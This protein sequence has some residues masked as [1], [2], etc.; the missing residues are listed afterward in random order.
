MNTKKKGLYV[1]GGIILLIIISAVALPFLVDVNHFRPTI[2]A[3]LKQTLCRP[4]QIGE[5][6]LS[7]LAGG[8]SVQNVVIGEDPAFGSAPFLTAK[9]LDVGVTMLPLLLSRSLDVNSFT[10][11]EPE[12]RLV[13]GNGG[14]WNFSSLGTSAPAPSNPG[15]NRRQS[16]NAPP[17]TQPASS[18]AP[19][20]S[21]GSLRITD[22]KILVSSVNNSRA[23]EYSNVQLKASDI[24]YTSIMP[25]NFEASTP[26]GGSLKADGKAGP[27]DREDTASTPLNA[28]VSIKHLDIASTGFV[29]P[30]SGLA[31]LLDYDGSL[32][33]NGKVAETQGKASVDKL[34]LVRSGSPAR[35]PV[36]FDY[37]TQYDL[38]RQQGSI[39]HGAIQVGKAAAALAGNYGQQGEA[40][41]VHMKFTGNNMPV[42]E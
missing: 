18:A 31:G 22:G 23:H 24:N 16:Q 13:R 1:V 36:R 8:V 2:E 25:F 41:V 6:H 9:S 5:M 15:R 19:N 28:I 4:V 37:S 20:V 27:L 30:A 21:I 39:Q 17:R 32:K 35:Q 26:G 11:R 33:S 3:R 38:K 40:T 34:R 42:Q 10:L 29:D 12:L 7:L 14:K